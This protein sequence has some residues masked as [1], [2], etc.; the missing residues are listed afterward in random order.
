MWQAQRAQKA[1]EVGSNFRKGGKNNAANRH[2]T[3]DAVFADF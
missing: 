1:S 2:L 3:E